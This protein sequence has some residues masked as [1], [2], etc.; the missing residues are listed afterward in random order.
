MPLQKGSSEKVISKN[1]AELMHSGRSQK[2]SV[3]IA[4][5]MAGKTKKKIS[6]HY[7]KE[8]VKMAKEMA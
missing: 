8:Q 7:S 1:I 3:A 4:M 6:G 2:Q 5:N